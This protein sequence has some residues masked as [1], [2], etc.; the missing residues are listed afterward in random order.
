MSQSHISLPTAG[1][2]PITAGLAGLIPGQGVMRTIYRAAASGFDDILAGPSLVETM[3]MRLSQQ[4][5]DLAGLGSSAFSDEDLLARD[6]IN[7]DTHPSTQLAEGEGLTSFTE[8]ICSLFIELFDLREKN[9]WLRRQAIVI[10]LQQILGGTIERQVAMSESR[11]VLMLRA[12]NF[13]RASQPPSGRRALRSTSKLFKTSSSRTV[14]SKSA[15]LQDQPSRSTR[16]AKRPT[17]G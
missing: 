12:A 16:L 15:K 9:N 1:V 14:N 10:I 13:V 2:M 17:G 8:P 3:V 7:P 4:A 11:Y 5:A 6:V